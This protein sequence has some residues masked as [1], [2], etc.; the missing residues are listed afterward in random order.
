MTDFVCRLRKCPTFSILATM[1]SM[2]ISA[3]VIL[4]NLSQLKAMYEKEWESIL[5]NCDSTLFLGG[6]EQTTLEYLSKRLG[7]ETIDTLS[8]SRSRGKSGSS[9]TNDGILGRELMTIDEMG[10]MKDDECILFVRGCVP[11]FS[12][13]FKI[14]RHMNYK[15][16]EDYNPKFAY[17]AENFDTIPAEVL[18]PAE[19]RELEHEPADEISN[20]VISD[21]NSILSKDTLPSEYDPIPDEIKTEKNDSENTDPIIIDD[22]KQAEFDSQPVT[23]IEDGD[24]ILIN[25]LDHLLDDMDDM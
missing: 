14:E 11:F 23:S 15:Q 4:Q 21:I 9:T 24:T 3:N 12:K 2:E 16:L 5:G 19:E 22:K 18:T 17:G 1:R 10:I 20:D 8:R 25:P 13:K 7:K 6:Q